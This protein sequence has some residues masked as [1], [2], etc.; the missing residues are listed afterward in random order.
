MPGPSNFSICIPSYKRPTDVCRAI[1][2]CLVQTGDFEIIIGDDTP[3]ESVATVIEQTFPAEPRIRYQHNV[4]SLGQ[5]GNVDS[6]FHKASGEWI[7]LL[8]DDDYLEPEALSIFRREINQYP[9]GTV[10]Y[11]KQ[12]V[13]TENARR[14]VAQSETFNQEFF[15]VKE[16]QGL[17]ADPKEAVLLLQVP[18]NGFC[19]KAGVAK[20]HGYP[21]LPDSGDACD[22]AFSAQLA[23]HESVFIFIDAYISTYV[24]SK[25][26]VVRNNPKNNLTL[27][28]MQIAERYFG[29]QRETPAFGLFFK[30]CVG[31]AVAQALAHGEREYARHLVKLAWQDKRVPRKAAVK[32]WLKC[33]FPKLA[34]L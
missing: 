19:L 18:S 30:N 15:R 34:L 32:A 1:K 7:V 21:G 14:D 24:L 28:A 27:R 13:E 3:G 22:W 9:G 16:R 20:A 6:L 26:S 2:S 25:K 33:A 8:H 23:L 4:P 11:G 12:Y 17:V 29:G 31:G 10:F 5:A